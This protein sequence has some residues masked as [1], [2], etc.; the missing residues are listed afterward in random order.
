VSAAIVSAGADVLTPLLFAGF[1]ALGVLRVEKCA[2]F[3][4]PHGTS[5]GEGVEQPALDQLGALVFSAD[6]RHWAS[7]ARRG[8]RPVLLT[9]GIEQA[10][11]EPMATRCSAR[12]AIASPTCRWRR[13]HASSSTGASLPSRCSCPTRERRLYFAADGG[14]RP[15]FDFAEQILETSAAQ[16]RRARACPTRCCAAGHRPR[17]TPPEQRR[18]S[19]RQGRAGCRAEAKPARLEQ[20]IGDIHDDGVSAPS[21]AVSRHGFGHR[22]ERH[23]ATSLDRPPFGA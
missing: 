11:R 22:S 13:P 6:G 3:S 2:P 19:K 21:H 23:A 12:R 8:G 9:D 7:A 17:P 15:S 20:R 14:A 5:L 1:H 4:F 16:T 18:N 10:L